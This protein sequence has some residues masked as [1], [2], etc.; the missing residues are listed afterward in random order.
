MK[1]FKKIA[2]IILAVVL[3]LPLA[4][5]VNAAAMKDVRV[6]IPTFKVTL[7]NEVI[8][9]TYSEYPLIV[10]KDI[11]YFPMTYFDSRWLGVTTDWSQE[12]GLSVSSERDPLKLTGMPEY[13]AY[14]RKTANASAY[15]ASTADFAITVNG[16]LIDNASEEY[17]LLLFRDIIYFPMTWRFCVDEF[18][19]Q[20]SWNAN[21]GLVIYSGTDWMDSVKYN[22]SYWLAGEKLTLENT[23]NDRETYTLTGMVYRWKSGE[24]TYSEVY[25]YPLVRWRGSLEVEND[26][27]FLNYN[28]YRMPTGLGQASGE[29]YHVCLNDVIDV[30]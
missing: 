2:A 28:T 26:K 10:Y 12:S 9:N 16:K 24:N 17:P 30:D 27:L 14:T 11:T 8:N 13:R 29:S 25:E 22:G 18:G 23:D 19:W 6:T 4:A 5:R 7:N 3:S 1:S 20:Y 15:T 21:D